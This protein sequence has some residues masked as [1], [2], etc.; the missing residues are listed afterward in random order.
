MCFPNNFA[1]VLKT[2]ILQNAKRQL[3]LKYLL[4]IKIAAPDKLL[5][6]MVCIINLTG[7]VK[8]N[9]MRFLHDKK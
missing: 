7:E 3:H 1:K 6:L 2:P 8:H 5:V 9:S 4:K